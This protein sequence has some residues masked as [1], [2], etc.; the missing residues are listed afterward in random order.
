MIR[1]PSPVASPSG[2]KKT[3]LGWTLSRGAGLHLMCIG[4]VGIPTFTTHTYTDVEGAFRE[5]VPD[6]LQLDDEVEPEILADTSQPHS[7]ELRQSPRLSRDL[8]RE[9]PIR[10]ET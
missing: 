6:D 8:G 7:T 4:A 2:S 10:K 1:S 5:P 3:L 9:M